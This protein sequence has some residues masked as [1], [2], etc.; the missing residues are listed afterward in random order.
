MK[1]DSSIKPTITPATTSAKPKPA[2]DKGDS[3][4]EVRLSALAGQ[5]Q[6]GDAEP[7]VNSVRVAEIRQAIAEGRFTIDTGAIADSLITTA[8]ELV[9]AQRKA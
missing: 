3:A 4:A 7:P 9:A 2:V 5:L 1:I 8:R 6:T